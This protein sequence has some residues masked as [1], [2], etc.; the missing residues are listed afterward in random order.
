MEEITDPAAYIKKLREEKGLTLKAMGE[1][2]GLSESGVW[3][4]E[5]RNT[6]MYTHTFLS[7][8]KAFKKKLYVSD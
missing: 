6:G 1:I 7:A 2:V 3:R 5:S 8:L 4:L